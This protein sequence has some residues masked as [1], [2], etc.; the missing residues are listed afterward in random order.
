VLS[1]ALDAVI[2]GWSV[3]RTTIYRTG[4]PIS[5]AFTVPSN[6]IGWWDGRT[7]TVAGADLYAGQQGGHDIV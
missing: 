1:R 2:G 5:L 6:Y 7:D 3:S 4:P